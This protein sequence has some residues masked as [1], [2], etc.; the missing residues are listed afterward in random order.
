MITVESL[1]GGIEKLITLARISI[2][3]RMGELLINSTYQRYVPRF[4]LCE[5]VPKYLSWEWKKLGRLITCQVIKKN[6][7]VVIIF[8]N[9]NLCQ[10]Y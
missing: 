6:F 7:V 8:N 4:S 10:K 3:N 9:G 2:K 5:D 1:I